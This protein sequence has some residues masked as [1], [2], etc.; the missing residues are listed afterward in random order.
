MDGGTA[1]LDDCQVCVGGTTGKT[2]CV[3]TIDC[4]GT[5]NGTATVDNCDR[6]VGGTTG[7]TACTS[8]DEAEVAACAFD[9][10]TET[11][12]A[13]Y[14]GA[15]YLNADNAVGSKI[16]FHITAASSGSHTLSFRYA[17][18]G[19]ADRP[20]T[21]LLNGIALPSQLSFP[22]TGAFTT[23]KTV[24]L[25]L[26]LNSGTHK[27]E[28]V[29]VTSEG[30]ANI[31][32]I[33]YVSSGLSKGTCGT[34]TDVNSFVNMS[35]I[36]IFPNPFADKIHVKAVGEFNYKIKTV[37]GEIIETGIIQDNSGIGQN[38]TPGFY[39]LELN[40]SRVQKNIKIIKT[41]Y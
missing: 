13:G 3:N 18:G 9:G 29:S 2:P 25:T 30:L 26:N 21:V 4:N 16:T 8:V 39:I 19:T 24:D 28:L 17:N 14:K 20:A 5:T 7:K 12:N 6:C 1:Y 37:S 40:N 38:L 34:I 31:D 27:L 15:S 36:E 41:S 35:G 10:I 33:G 11:K 22:V 32:Q 23:Y